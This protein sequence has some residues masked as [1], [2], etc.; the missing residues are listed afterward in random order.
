MTQNTLKREDKK[1][2]MNTNKSYYREKEM[3]S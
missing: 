1:N 2:Q 3:E